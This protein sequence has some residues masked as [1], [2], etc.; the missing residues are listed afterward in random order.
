MI[1]DECQPCCA[2]SKHCTSPA[3]TN[4]SIRSG[5]VLSPLGQQAV[6]AIALLITALQCFSS[7]PVVDSKRVVRKVVEVNQLAI[8]LVNS[9]NQHPN[10][11]MLC[12]L[13]CLLPD[14]AMLSVYRYMYHHVIDNIS[15]PIC[16][17][18]HCCFVGRQEQA[19]PL[20]SSRISTRHRS[21]S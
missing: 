1:P 7:R 15:K 21:A 2:G 4:S 8:G 13:S 11:G 10:K 9:P 16:A 12:T 20:R 6:I 14:L 18:S 19:W 3:A 5:A 17:S